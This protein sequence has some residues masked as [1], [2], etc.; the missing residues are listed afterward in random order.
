LL[1]KENAPTFA[2]EAGTFFFFVYGVFSIV[3]NSGL[4][5]KI[6]GCSCRRNYLKVLGA[7]GNVAH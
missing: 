7:L 2:F 5:E 6:A 4:R 3:L 1:L